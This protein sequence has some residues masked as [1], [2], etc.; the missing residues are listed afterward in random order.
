MLSFDDMLTLLPNT[1]LFKRAHVN[2]AYVQLALT[3]TIFDVAMLKYNGKPAAFVAIASGFTEPITPSKWQKNDLVS[4]GHGQAG[5]W[6]G[7]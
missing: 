4:G 3:T 6:R 2:I 7:Q 5:S 1:W